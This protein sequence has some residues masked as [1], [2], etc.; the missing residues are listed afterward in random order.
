M[1]LLPALQ[2]GASAAAGVLQ[3][4]PCHMS[5]ICCLASSDHPRGSSLLLHPFKLINHTRLPQ[6]N[7][8]MSCKYR[9]P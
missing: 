6:L 2:P 3:A 4:S 7:G 1:F 8:I 5:Q 9:G